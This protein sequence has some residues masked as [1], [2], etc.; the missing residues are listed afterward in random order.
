MGSVA[1]GL[2]RPQ[3]GSHAAVWWSPSALELEVEENVGLKQKKLLEADERGTRSQAGVL[4]HEAWQAQRARV[5]ELGATPTVRV[6]T[7]TER[8]AVMDEVVEVAVEVVGGPATRPHGIRFGTLVHAVL[9]AVDLASP[10]AEVAAVAAVE[11][12]VLG[13]PTDEVEAAT[14]AVSAALAHPV[15]RQ[16]AAAKRLRRE[17]PLAIVL[18]DGTLVEGIVDAAFEDDDG[19]TVVD[20]K[21]DVEVAGRLEEYRRQVALYARAIEK[22]TGRRARSVL[23]R[24]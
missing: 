22:A 20:F 19:W 15:L 18:D 10:R 23:L 12:R 6:V 3:V 5:R 8:A 9:A 4:A 16:A 14:D 24:V 13:A 1:P 21:T 7:A 2:H 11:G 17:T